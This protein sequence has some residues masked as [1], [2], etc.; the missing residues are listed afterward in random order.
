M[1]K[2]QNKSNARSTTAMLILTSILLGIVVG[3]VLGALFLYTYY[4][5]FVDNGGQSHVNTTYVT[6]D[7]GSACLYGQLANLS[8]DPYQCTLARK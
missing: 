2:K 8:Q 6:Y 7:N 1:A 3:F 4:S 5:Q